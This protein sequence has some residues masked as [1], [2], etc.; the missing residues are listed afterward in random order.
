M[1]ITVDHERCIGSGQCVVSAAAVFD[2]DEDEGRVI[3]LIESPSDDLLADV[4]EAARV[5]P[6]RAIHVDPQG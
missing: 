3:L 5:C 6:A 4:Q 1:K 2:Q